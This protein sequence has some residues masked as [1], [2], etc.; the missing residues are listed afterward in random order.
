VSD[1]SAGQQSDR[2][3]KLERVLAEYLHSVE[4]GRPLNRLTLLADH[5]DLA[6][7]LQSF[8]RNRD[9]IDRLAEPLK[10]AVDAPTL[11]ST[12]QPDLSQLGTA[13][14]YFGDYEL[15]EEI[16]RGGMGV[17]YKARQVNLN[18]VVALKMILAGQLA[19]D[20]DVK[21]FYAEAEAAASLDHAGIVP[22]FEIGQH[23]GQSYFSMAFIEGES[24]AKKV[25]D[26]P[27]PP[28]EAAEMVR[29][30]AEAVE[31]AHQRG[32]IHRDLKP[33]NVLLDGRQQ[34]KVTD[35][36]LAKHTEGDSG[37]TGTGQILGTPSYM[38][39][40]QAAG[41]LDQIGPHSDVYALGAILYC[42]TTGRP[43]FQ[44]ASPIDTI[45]Q[46]LDQEPA[47]PRQLNRH[48]PLDLETMTLKC[49]EKEPA[50]RYARSADLA[51]ELGRFLRGEP[52]FARPIGSLARSWRWCRRNRVVATLLGAVT[53][54]VATVAIVS[55]IAALRL[56]AEHKETQKLL[57]ITQDAVEKTK[58]AEHAATHRLYASLVDQARANRLSRRI[59]QR[60]K[61]LDVL[62]EASQMAQELRLP[63]E[64]F[65]KLRN[66]AIACLTLTD[67]RM[68]REWE[69]W[70][71][72]SHTVEF[73]G[74]LER[75]AHTDREGNVS[76]RR[77]ADGTELWNLPTTSPG[78]AWTVLSADGHFMTVTAP[79]GIK[80]W[81]LSGHEPRVMLQR[82]AEGNVAFS[83]NSRQLAIRA[84]NGVVTR[85]ELPSGRELNRI[86]TEVSGGPIA[87]HPDGRQLAVG[88]QAGVQIRDVETGTV[89]KY[90]LHAG[91]CYFV[92]W[93]PS[94]KTVAAVGPDRTIQIWDVSTGKATIQLKGHTNDGIYFA[95]SHNGDLLASTGWGQ[96]LRLWDPRTGELLFQHPVGMQSLRFSSDDRHLAV[97]NLQNGKLGLI[98]IAPAAQ[99]YRTLV[100]DPAL[101]RGEYFPPSLSPDGRLL[102]AGMSDG[103]GIWDLAS[104]NPLRFLPGGMTFSVLFEPSGALLTS[105]PSGVRRWPFQLDAAAPGTIRMGP[106]Q[107][108][109]LFGFSSTI[110]LSRDG[111]V[112]AKAMYSG[113]A[114]W[115]Q[116][117]LIPPLQ[118]GPHADA[119]YIAVSPDGCLVA[120]GS[121]G[122][123]KV[124]IW[125]TK[126]G[127]LVRELP[128]EGG[129]GVLF[130]SDG[131]RLLTSWNGLRLWA[132]D[133]WQEVRTIGG[134]GGAAF[135]PDNSVLAAERGNGVITLID[136]ETGDEY[137]R[138]ED[139]HQDRGGSPCFSADGAQLAV[140]N[141]DS[142]S[143]HV[144]NL[145]DIRRQ[146]SRMGL[147][148]NLPPYESAE[149]A[150]DAV[151]LAALE[152]VRLLGGILHDGQS[153]AQSIERQVQS[154]TSGDGKELSRLAYAPDGK[155]IALACGGGDVRLWDTT[156]SSLRAVLQGH[157][158]PA[159]A[160]AF[161]P[162]GSI[163][164]TG[165][166]D[167][168]KP[169]GPGE[170]K[171]WD[172]R[173]G[174]FLADLK[175]HV[176]PVW[177]LAFS[178]D[179]KTLASG[180]TD[181]LVKLWDPLRRAARATLD[182]GVR[183]WVRGVAFTPDDK[184]L[185][186]SHMAS[187]RWWN[188]ETEQVVAELNGH[189]EEINALAISPD[190]TMLATA[191]RDQTAI[192]WDL[193]AQQKL[194]TIAENKGWV[195]DVAFAPDGKA[196]AFSVMDGSVKLWDI[197]QG[198]IRAAGRDPAGY[199]LC[200]GFS[201]DGSTVASGQTELVFWKF[202][203]GK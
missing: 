183:F 75:Y 100:R 146:L 102:A 29:K 43:P 151:P 63:E 68:A 22:I 12:S 60:F 59:G 139:P 175:G 47:A 158:A 104:G 120:T 67:V 124:K 97:G 71:T 197:A 72:G 66:E 186:S 87:Y 30:V 17:V 89:S 201:P 24:L 38:P 154:A 6:D 54:L 61:T 46:V 62:R 76:I 150:G 21:R 103:I 188:L 31:Y 98:E 172:P 81:D 53:V 117:P 108:L 93:H 65:L 26:G 190:G 128:V 25:V 111:Q 126:S 134:I 164:A 99:F 132:T 40:E 32:I 187:V 119:R 1:Q 137:A 109:P 163:L 86:S 184:H 162:D 147:D 144:W 165:S 155:T 149:A 33:A 58:Q 56:D 70:P 44:A 118:L 156:T 168:Q 194:A 116:D 152:E 77:V 125:D 39:P 105:E 28:R 182:P 121:H 145:R 10:A 15:L 127:E 148:W 143:I 142:N 7:D 37:L 200:V 4:K 174:A 73:D 79:D 129:S 166:G 14:R 160:L 157:T 2:Q 85:F 13:V 96:P 140:A 135:S 138:L 51:D 91:G 92:G 173:T 27:L 199:A 141:S 131:R 181:G 52:I 48:V 196:L 133:S 176:G 114:V 123:T 113:G 49:L 35:F 88:H 90:L 106:P 41:K 23:E 122:G 136:P 64:D 5:P 3:A 169:D 19:N 101:G 42:L 82:L 95:F 80:V 55:T 11:L 195:T 45:K 177:S 107:Q 171:L 192:V 159:L 57:K 16:A 94:G 50:R 185:V 180:A 110:S 115:H 9:S 20:S 193:A 202:G 34:P 83:P 8:F 189:S 69:G 191:S 36:G 74:A 153:D 170:I 203:I 178:R 130:S 167:W 78:Q 179:G 112:I 84:V 161:A 198:R 18:R